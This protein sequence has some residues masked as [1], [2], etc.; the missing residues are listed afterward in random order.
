MSQADTSGFVEINE[1]KVNV[2]ALRKE[3]KLHQI[4]LGRGNFLV[5]ETF[6]LKARIFLSQYPY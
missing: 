4:G 5:E 2:L 1:T 3:M 6:I